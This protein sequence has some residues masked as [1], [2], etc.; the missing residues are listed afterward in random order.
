MKRVLILI[1]A[2]STLCTACHKEEKIVK[3]DSS[4]RFLVNFNGKYGY[5]DQTGITQF[6]SSSIPPRCFPKG[7][8]LYVSTARMAISMSAARWQFRQVLHRVRSS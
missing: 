7:W 5:C 4:Y 3:L 2:L 1:L 6:H 8:L